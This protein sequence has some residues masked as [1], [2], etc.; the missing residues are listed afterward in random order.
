MTQRVARP[1]KFAA[2]IS[3]IISVAVIFAAC[4]GAVGPKGPKGDD[5][6]DGVDG[7][8]GTAGAPAFQPLSAKAESP[9]VVITDATD[10]DDMVVAGAAQTI[11]LA[12]YIYGTAERKYGTPTSTLNAAAQ[13]FDAKLDGSMLTITPKAPQPTPASYVVQTFTVMI[14]D[15]GESTAIPLEIPARRNQKPVTPTDVDP[16][17]EGQV[18]TQA[19]A[20]PP[21]DVLACG[22]ADGNECYIDVTF[23]DP[24]FLVDS[25]AAEEKLTFTATSSD[26]TKFVVVSV[27]NGVDQSMMTQPLVARVVVRGVA[28]TWDADAGPPA[29]HD[30]VDVIIVATDEGGATVRGKAQIEV[31]GEP[32]AT[33]VPGGTVSAS[34]LTFTIGDVTGYFTDPD[35]GDDELTYEAAVTGGDKNAVTAVIQT[36][37]MGFIVTRNAPGTAEVT[38]TATEMDDNDGPEQSVKAVVTI[39]SS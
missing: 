34:Q 2:F 28:S 12:D 16:E 15:G 18:G 20:E 35:G 19:L 27:G 39:T 21:D 11:D 17:A 24:D 1:M 38:I 23:T 22:T 33:T 5:G 30:P 13:V 31:D 6:A 9:S 14:S 36:S 25:N 8:D 10:E 32:T 37:G 3:I 29:A 7:T 4:Q 26:T